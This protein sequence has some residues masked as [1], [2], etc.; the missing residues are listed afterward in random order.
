MIIIQTLLHLFPTFGLLVEL[1]S[2][3]NIE[4]SIDFEG[5]RKILE[6]SE[7]FI[8]E[9]KHPWKGLKVQKRKHPF[10]YNNQTIGLLQDRDYQLKLCDCSQ[11]INPLIKKVEYS[12]HSITYTFRY[13]MMLEKF[14]LFSNSWYSRNLS[15]LDLKL[16]IISGDF[17]Y[18]INLEENKINS[19]K[20]M[21]KYKLSQRPYLMKLRVLLNISHPRDVMS[22]NTYIKFY[23]CSLVCGGIKTS[24]TDILY[25]IQLQ[26]DFPTIC[27]WHIQ[28]VR[29][30]SIVFNVL[31]ME[32]DCDA[33]NI[34]VADGSRPFFES[35]NTWITSLSKNSISM[36]ENLLY[37]SIWFYYIAGASTKIHVEHFSMI[38][39]GGCDH[40]YILTEKEGTLNVSIHGASDIQKMKFDCSVFIR[41]SDK[42]GFI[43]SFQQFYLFSLTKSSCTSNYVMIYSGN[44]EINNIPFCDSISPPK[45]IDARY[46]WIRLK[47][48]NSAPIY[49]IN[50]VIQYLLLEDFKLDK[51]TNHISSNSENDYEKTAS[52]IVFWSFVG[53]VLFITLI[54]VTYGR[55]EKTADNIRRYFLSV[56][57]RKKIQLEEEIRLSE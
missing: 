12:Y 15:T 48:V 53:I 5:V 28:P 55:I 7:C 26:M 9:D 27:L 45:Y 49:D 40:Q 8:L 44:S 23:G 41:R 42:K 43:I 24:V 10:V 19:D 16:Q 25:Y 32:L 3:E 33:S 20:K 52:V 51:Y 57:R 47:I 30:T 14:E 34:I 29:S 37:P 1:K 54:V 4:G 22:N 31:D 13:M 21:L 2:F 18:N 36:I 46:G 39:H 35:K 17:I 50:M 6:W 38:Y 56:I 11:V